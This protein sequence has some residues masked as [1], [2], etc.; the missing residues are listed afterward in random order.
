MQGVIGNTYHFKNKGLS[1]SSV[2]TPEKMIPVPA[3][4]DIV[5]PLLPDS[6]YELPTLFAKP[7]Q[8]F[9]ANMLHDLIVMRKAALA[10]IPAPGVTMSK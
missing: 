4:S 6:S 10:K 3:F 5:Y 7:A 2:D 8:E 9:P 1:A